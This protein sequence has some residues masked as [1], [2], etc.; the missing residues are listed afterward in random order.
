MQTGDK[1][2]AAAAIA[3]QL[4][5]SECYGGAVLRSSQK[6]MSVVRENVIAAADATHSPLYLP[7]LT[8]AVMFDPASF[9]L[10]WRACDIIGTDV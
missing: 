5:L 8:S 3:N 6:T 2:R 9:A 10:F 7:S 4:P 1:E